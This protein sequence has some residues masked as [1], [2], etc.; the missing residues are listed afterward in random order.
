[1]RADYMRLVIVAGGPKA[2]KVSS[3]SEQ[4]VRVPARETQGQPI[5]NGG[6]WIGDLLILRQA[7]PDVENRS[8][9]EDMGDAQRSELEIGRVQRFR[10]SGK[11]RAAVW[12]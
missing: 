4:A 3:G 8:G 6:M 1:M 10:P 11:I 12:Q 5:G 2:R 7:E 9:A